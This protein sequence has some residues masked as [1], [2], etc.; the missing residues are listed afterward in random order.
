MARIVRYISDIF[1]TANPCPLNHRTSA[2]GISMRCSFGSVTVSE[3]V[4][5]GR[6]GKSPKNR[7]LVQEGSQCLGPQTDQ[8]GRSHRGTNGEATV[9]RIEKGI[10]ASQGGSVHCRRG[11]IKPQG[12]LGEYAKT[13]FTRECLG[14]EYCQ[15]QWGESLFST[16]DT[17][18][19]TG[20]S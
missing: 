15:Y 9:G 4:Y 19:Q 7:Q 12:G 8:R 2:S 5:P 11:R 1:S 10:G 14:R 6:I 3:R 20:L 13:P 16:P 17:Q 18:S